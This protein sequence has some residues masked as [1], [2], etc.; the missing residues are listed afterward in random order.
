MRLEE[1]SRCHVHKRQFYH[2]ELLLDGNIKASSVFHSSSCG[3]MEL[4]D[5]SLAPLRLLF[6]LSLCP[7]VLA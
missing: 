5:S 2:C 4:T 6:H 1:A 3:M 7:F